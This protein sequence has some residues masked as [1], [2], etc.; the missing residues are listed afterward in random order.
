MLIIIKIIASTLFLPLFLIIDTV[1]SDRSGGRKAGYVLIILMFFATGWIWA[2][3][4]LFFGTQQLLFELGITDQLTQVHV[5]GTSMMPTIKDGE[6]LSLHSP[7][8]YGLE[9]GDIISFKNIETG[10][11]HYMKRIVALENEQITIINGQ[12]LINNQVP[13]EDYIFNQAPTYGNTFITECQTFTVPQDH[14]L[15]LGDNRI[16]STDSRIVGFVKKDFIDGVIKTHMAYQ[17]SDPSGHPQL[18]SSEINTLEF[19]KLLNEK[20]LEKDQSPLITHNTLNSLAQQRAK[21]ITSNFTDWKNQL[22]PVDQLLDQQGYRFNQVHEFVTFGF[23]GESDVV[24][25]ILESPIQ[26]SKFLSDQY[27]EVGIGVDQMNQDQCT[28]SVISVLLSWPANPSY[29]QE[30]KDF[31]AEEVTTLTDIVQALQV[32]LTSPNVDQTQIRNLINSLSEQLE[33]ATRIRDRFHSD[34]WLTE[35][36]HQD[37]DKYNQLTLDNEQQLADFYQQITGQ[38][39]P[40]FPSSPSSSTLSPTPTPSQLQNNQQLEVEQGITLKINQA[41]MENNQIWI[42]YTFY[43]TAVS[44]FKARPALLMKNS[45]YTVTPAKPVTQEFDLAVGQ[46]R[47]GRQ[48]FDPLDNP[49]FTFFYSSTGGDS[50]ELGTFTP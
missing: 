48:Y 4:Q 50:I 43:R 14:F 29:D 34:Q 5:S 36:D 28:I 44:P 37:V 22:L 10:P 12:L 38:P 11:R 1:K 23:L 30:T 20:R 21:Q 13:Q 2:Y 19:I 18:T 46:G 32:F 27:Y 45:D 31:W 41:W 40:G 33:I 25:Q 15:V 16:V 26:K 47:S 7:K 9:R 8:K 49:P 24:N 6:T 3:L 42:S 17:F 39:L 35:Q